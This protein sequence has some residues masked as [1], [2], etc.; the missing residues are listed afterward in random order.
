AW[1]P[2][3]HH[4]EIKPML[5]PYPIDPALTAIAVAYKNDDYIA[6]VVLPRIL[7]AKQEFKFLQYAS[8][9]QYTLVDT[10]VG[11]RSKPNE[12]TLD[13]TEITDS[14]ED[15]ALDGGVPRAD[16]ENADERY[17]PLGNE[18]MFIQELIALGR[19]QRAASLVHSAATYSAGLKATLAGN[20][21]FN[22]AAYA[23]GSVIRTIGRALDL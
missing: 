5:S 3:A 4:E 2:K 21:Q 7:V 9:Q 6:D 18:V 11:R 17:D 13:A 12:V 14:T 19:E 22:D 15:H 23:G 20:M 10:R 16:M 1:K 8:D